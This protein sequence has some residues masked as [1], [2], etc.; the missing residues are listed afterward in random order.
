MYSQ[1][2]V[3]TFCP[4][5]AFSNKHTDTTVTGLVAL[6]MQARLKRS[7]LKLEITKTEE[8]NPTKSSNL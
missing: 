3:S 5:T 8:H 6:L 2:T 4:F 1:D 7:I